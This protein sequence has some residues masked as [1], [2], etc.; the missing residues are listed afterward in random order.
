MYVLYFFRLRSFEGTLYI[1]GDNF[2][3]DPQIEVMVPLASSLHVGTPKLFLHFQFVSKVRCI[4][5]T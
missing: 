1:G 5:A 3:I 2:H 4:C